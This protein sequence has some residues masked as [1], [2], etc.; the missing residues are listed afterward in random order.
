M[1]MYTEKG[2]IREWKQKY[3]KTPNIVSIAFGYKE[4][5][6]KNGWRMGYTE[7]GIT[8]CGSGELKMLYG[9]IWLDY[10][11]LKCPDI[12]RDAVLWHEF[13]HIWDATEKLH[14]D[15]CKGFYRKLFRKPVYAICDILLK[16]IGWL[17]FD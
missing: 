4:L 16:F 5:A 12:F 3:I 1:N 9:T 6:I 15:H 14:V 2:L 8:K 7:C 11:C 17:W 10:G 13:C